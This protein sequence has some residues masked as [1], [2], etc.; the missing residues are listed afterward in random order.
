MSDTN[1]RLGEKKTFVEDDGKPFKIGAH[2]DVMHGFYTGDPPWTQANENDTW[3]IAINAK[4]GVIDA[5]RHQIP[6]KVLLRNGQQ[7]VMLILDGATGEIQQA[8]DI[9]TQG[10]VLVIRNDKIT[11]RLD[12]DTGDLLLGGGTPNESHIWLQ[13]SKG[14]AFL[15]GNIRL[16]GGAGRATLGIAGANGSLAVNNAA[17]NTRIQLTGER[18]NGQFGGNVSIGTTNP[19]PEQLH[20]EG[21]TVVAGGQSE[22]LV[23]GNA[24]IGTTDSHTERL[25][26]AG[27][28]VITD[29]AT[30]GTGTAHSEQLYVE[31]KAVVGGAG[32]ELL[33]AGKAG[34]GTV[35]S[36]DERLYVDGAAHLGRTSI[37]GALS[38]DGPGAKLLVNGNVSVGTKIDH[39]DKL[40][41][42]GNTRIAARLDVAGP[43]SVGP[44]DIK[45]DLDVTGASTLHGSLVVD[46]SLGV[47]R[48][49]MAAKG[50]AVQ[51]FDGDFASMA[52]CAGDDS[53]AGLGTDKGKKVDMIYWDQAHDLVFGTRKS[54]D[55]VGDAFVREV[56]KAAS[57]GKVF[58]GKIEL[59]GGSGDIRLPNGDCAEDFE[60]ADEDLEPGTVVVIQ[61]EGKLVRS[62]AAYDRRVAGV[63]S[64]AG[65]YRPGLILDQQP[66]AKGKRLPVALMGKVFCKVD[67][68][69][70]PIEVGDLLTPAPTAGHAM[71]A[72]DPAR[73]FGAVIGK[74]LRALPSGKGLIP[75]L[76]AL[77]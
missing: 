53:F 75:V 64:G 32:A 70:S 11:I 27:K 65:E 9:K 4:N 41:V 35:A 17:G 33:V 47:G 56:M 40:Y 23:A 20:I 48:P 66:N 68:D 5:G 44:T 71:K 16:E 61:D 26:V 14:N 72:T 7:E 43:T 54:S 19:F 2:S 12:G 10:D 62:Q 69:L 60:I 76:V 38:V 39:S 31:G 67:A 22:L 36:H 45:G 77:Q 73:A 29:G 46:A 3:V 52:V 13:G 37:D 34:I 6:G 57:D 28:A 8:G 74:A 63:I 15:G 1:I 18:G 49:A 30:I 25:H 55:G 50:K 21:K 51:V 24:G 59:D 42:E 58:V